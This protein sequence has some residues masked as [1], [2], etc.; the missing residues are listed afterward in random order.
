MRRS[1]VDALLLFFDL[2]Q[3]AV[4]YERAARSSLAT[5]VGSGG[6]WQL[7]VRCL[8]RDFS[9]SEGANNSVKREGNL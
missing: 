2:L 7:S 8:P 6:A 5:R 9:M 4:R 3:T 1:V